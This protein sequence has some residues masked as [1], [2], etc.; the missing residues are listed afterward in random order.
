[1]YDEIAKAYEKNWKKLNVTGQFREKFIRYA[2]KGRIADIG[3]GPGIS[4]HYFSKKFN[5]VGVDSSK[6]MI[7][8]ARE[9]F[10]KLDFICIDMR[11]MRFEENSLDG[12]WASQSL[13]HIPK[14]DCIAVLRN[15]KKC[16]KNGGIL[17]ISV[18]EGSFEGF[19]DKSK[20]ELFSGRKRFIAMYTEDELN[21]ILSSLNYKII[22]VSKVRRRLSIEPYINVFA[23]NIK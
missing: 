8:I 7:K 23:K 15:I 9:R 6:E 17:F 22:G 3:C 1:M 16:L 21:E 2:R 12:I 18:R 4:T 14:K 13:H 19:T 20:N 5:V 10:P 11:K